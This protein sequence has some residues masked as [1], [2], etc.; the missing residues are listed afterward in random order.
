MQNKSDTTRR[1]SLAKWLLG[2]SFAAFGAIL[3]APIAQAEFKPSLNLY[4]ATGLI[5]MPSGE[6]QSDGL[7][8]MTS[9]HFGPIS[10]NTLS[11]QITP[12]LSASFRFLG[13]RDWNKTAAS[14]A[15][16]SCASSTGID[17]FDTYYD[18]SFDLRFKALDE[19]RYLPAVTIGLQDFAGTGILS[20]EYV[21]ATKNVT[22]N[23]KVT[24]G[25]G[26]GRLGSHGSIGSPFGV[27]P[28]ID[29]G[30]G[31]NFNIK[32][33]FRGPVAPFAGIEWKFNDQWTLKGEYSSDDYAEEAGKRSTFKRKSS[34]NFGVE[35]QPSEYF[36]V[37]AYY[38][39]GSTVGIAGQ[40][41]ID[42]KKRHN[43][44]IIDRAP[45]PVKP[46]PSRSSDPEAWST[47]WVAQADAGPI[48]R[49]NVAKRLKDDGIVVEAIAYSAG[50][51]QIRIRNTRYYNNAQAIGRTA[52]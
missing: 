32:Q 52:R 37:G 36:R 40:F 8:S 16:S 33:W 45:N 25:L 50:T 48:L 5:D 13:I 21:A 47:D 49:G 9:S 11:F 2:G 10:R 24:A 22:P 1:K 7:L 34:Y 26:W 6:A 3:V 19:G 42:P 28:A 46:R 12:R 30:Y 41:L 4:G 43:G 44:G 51:V 18:R 29:V 23:L 38:M 39:Y 14:Q 20:G 31:G 35:Y 15:T 27:R 17:Q